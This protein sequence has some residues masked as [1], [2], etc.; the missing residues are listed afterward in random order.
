M[1]PEILAYKAALA[2]LKAAEEAASAQRVVVAKLSEMVKTA[3][4][5]CA[6]QRIERN[7]GGYF[8]PRCGFGECS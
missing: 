4:L 2:A 1:L 6:H 8:C 3:Q 5:E 7:A